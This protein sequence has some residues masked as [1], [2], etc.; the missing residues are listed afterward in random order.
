MVEEPFGSCEAEV[1][2]R[3]RHEGGN[4]MYINTREKQRILGKCRR[5]EKE[6]NGCC[7]SHFP[8]ILFVWKFVGRHREEQTHTPIS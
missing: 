1:G 5:D 2:G 7:K 8:L 6:E 4:F 3:R